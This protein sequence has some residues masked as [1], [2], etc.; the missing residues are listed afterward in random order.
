[1]L[2]KIDFQNY[3][4]MTQQSEYFK[5]GIKDFKEGKVKQPEIKIFWVKKS[6][7]AMEWKNIYSQISH[8]CFLRKEDKHIWVGFLT[9]IHIPYDCEEM[10]EMELLQVDD[11]RRA[12]NIF[13]TPLTKMEK[14]KEFAA[15]NK[16]SPAIKN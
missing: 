10:N 11:Y 6:V 15:G 16:P 13:P 8:Y 14:A 3:K 2:E 7:S 1:M 4:E 9:A 12:N 5:Q